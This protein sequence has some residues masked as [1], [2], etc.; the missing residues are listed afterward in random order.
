MCQA[1]VCHAPY[2]PAEG[3]GSKP[4][5]ERVKP[6]TT[7]IAVYSLEKCEGRC[8][9]RCYEATTPRC[10]CVCGG[11]NH[12][13]GEKQATEN[14][15]LYADEMITA[16]AKQKNLTDYRGFVPDDVRQI[17]LFQEV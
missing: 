6:M 2:R 1:R 16:Y 13:V 17:P 9:A 7:L 15:R 5:E 4:L 12:G 10:F 3:E 11:M 14:T 8:D